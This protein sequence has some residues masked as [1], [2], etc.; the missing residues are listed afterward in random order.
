S[1]STAGK[2]LAYSSLNPVFEVNYDTPSPS[3]I[4]G[5]EYKSVGNGYGLDFGLT[6]EIFKQLRIAVAIND[7]G[8]IKWDGNV[9]E[10]ED[11]LLENIETAGLNNYNI[12]EEGQNIAVEN[13]NW[14]EW[15]GLKEKTV[16]LPTR[17]R[18]GATYQLNKK[19]EFGT[20]F[21]VPVKK[22]VPGGYD[23][24][25]WGMGTRIFPV[26]WLRCSAGVVTGGNLGVGIPLGISFFPFN[27]KQF[28]WE[29][30]IAISDVTTYFKQDN[31]NVSLAL[32]LI[33]FSF[34]NIR[35]LNG[36]N[37]EVQD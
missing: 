11:G 22:D 24:I 16:E 36:E 3:M 34:G 20:D 6:F 17:F 5:N 26:K 14:G 8:S 37:I 12:F 19:I 35:D 32:G 31:P 2:L 30:G 21:A 13:T 9:Y 7:I 23:K 10:G 33:R 1:Y 28:S 27:N 18:G 25:I 15:E 4:N 29:L